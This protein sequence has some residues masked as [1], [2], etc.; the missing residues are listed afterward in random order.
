MSSVRRDP[1]DGRWLARWRDPAGRQRKKSFRR[2]VDA[3]RFLA[4]L[5][6]EMNRGGYVDPAAGKLSVGAFA[7]TWMAGLGHLKVSTAERYRETVRTHVLPQWAGWPLA[8]V[9]HSDIAAWLGGLSDAGMSPGLV[10]K[11]HLVT[12]LIFRAAVMDGR[13]A[14]NPAVG[15]RLPR[16]LPRERR[17]LTGSELARLAAAAGDD[18]LSILVLGLT[19]LRFG[20]FAA[21]R[22]RRVD[23][24]RRRLVVA[25]SVT[26]V[27]SRL[28]WSTPKTHRTRSVPVPPALMPAILRSC[29][30]KSGDD[31][32]FTAARGGA[33]RLNN[34]RRR[35]FDPACEAAGI[36]GVTPHDLRHTAAS[37]AI[38]AGANV[39][40]VQQM[41]G[42]AS[43]AM[44]LDIY[45][46]LFPDDLDAVG[47]AL[48]ALVP[49]TCHNGPIGALGAAPTAEQKGS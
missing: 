26:V 31:L 3:D 41:L 38:A 4:E 40:A 1:R 24:L 32:V 20:E 15:V 34:W 17:F 36:R 19:G 28:V 8:A 16:Q 43:A 2:R 6:A 21:L 23:P 37:L 7:E 48:D 39:K 5:T 29:D 33:L 45:A 14:R 49:Q 47:R 9:T 35:V 44:T 46:G 30:G 12:S 22:V 27:G 11:V 18:G 10:R 42:H 25:E 13:I